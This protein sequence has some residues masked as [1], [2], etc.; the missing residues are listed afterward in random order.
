MKL[1]KIS[2]DVSNPHHFQDL[3]LKSLLAKD[4]LYVLSQSSGIF[5]FNINDLSINWNYSSNSVPTSYPVSNEFNIYYLTIDKKIHLINKRTGNIL[6]EKVIDSNSIPLTLAI[7]NNYLFVG[8]TKG[9]ILI[10]NSVNGSYIDKI[11]VG[12]GLSSDIVTYDNK[13]IFVSNIGNLYSV[14]IRQ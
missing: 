14:L 12:S 8:L 10:Y 4:A 9:D 2:T 5:S 1:K 6:W 7:M 13:L 3:Y 11:P